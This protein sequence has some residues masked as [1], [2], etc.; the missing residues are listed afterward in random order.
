M[1]P[2][3][4]TLLNLKDVDCYDELPETGT[5]IKSNASQKARYAFEKYGMDCFADDT[6]LEVFSLQGRPGVY[7]ARYAGPKCDS[8]DNIKKILFEMKGILDRRA[9]FKTVIVLF[10]DGIEYF[11]E[12]QI[13]G[14]ISEEPSGGDGFGY[15]PVFRPGTGS[16][17]FSEM[18]EDAKNLIS[19]RG[20]AIKKLIDFLTA[21]TKSK[22]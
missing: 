10:F 3:T 15:D 17:T 20:L 1:L 19:H 8:S 18:N 22:F 2:A 12:G 14:F 11:F 21:K 13:D 5:S 4:F 16:I 7:S 9:S 6:G